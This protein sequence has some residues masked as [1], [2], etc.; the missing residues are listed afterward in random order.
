MKKTNYYLPKKRSAY[1]Y[2]VL[3]YQG[4]L[5]ENEYELVIE[6]YEDRANRLMCRIIAEKL[7][8]DHFFHVQIKWMKANRIE[9]LRKT[10][11]W[12]FEERVTEGVVELELV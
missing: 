5:P 1:Q 9:L 2:C 8:D 4:N 12:L 10:Q 6:E 11:P 3:Q 7:P